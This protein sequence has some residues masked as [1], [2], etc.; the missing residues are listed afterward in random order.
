MVVENA[1]IL[2]QERNREDQQA[3]AALVSADVL[4]LEVPEQSNVTIYPIM[5]EGNG[6]LWRFYRGCR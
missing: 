4:D 3:R 5:E 2:W 1:G 6:C